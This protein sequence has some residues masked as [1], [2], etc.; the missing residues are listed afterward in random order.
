M[1]KQ[2][3]CLS[4]PTLTG[5]DDQEPQMISSTGLTRSQIRTAMNPM[6]T[7]TQHC[8][9][10]VWPQGVITLQ[11]TVG[12]NGRVSDVDVTDGGGMDPALI[13]C[14]QDTLRYTGF[15]PHDMPDG[16]TF[17]Y[18]LRFSSDTP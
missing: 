14:V 15:P 1:P 12:C 3:P 6:M 11:V 7:K 4:G 13:A 2:Q 5:G 9:D 10:G 8:I 16:Y 17:G 18:P